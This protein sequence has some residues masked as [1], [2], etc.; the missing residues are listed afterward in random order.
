MANYSPLTNFSIKKSKASKE[1]KGTRFEN[2]YFDNEMNQ[3]KD[4]WFNQSSYGQIQGIGSN[5]YYEKYEDKLE[6]VIV[7]VIDSGVDVNHED[8]DG[9][10]WIN[11]NEI[12]NNGID[13]DGNGYI[14]DVMGW[15]FIG[16]SDY[17]A[18]FKLDN[19]KMNG[20]TLINN[21]EGQVEFDS[22]EITRETKR[23]LNLQLNYE[24]QGQIFPEHLLDKLNSYQE[25]VQ[26]EY[27]N[28]L[29]SL[30]YFQ[31]EQSS[32]TTLLNKVKATYNLKEV[33]LRVLENLEFKDSDAYKLID[34]Y[35]VYD[36]PEL[37]IAQSVHH[38]NGISNYHYNINASTRVD[39]VKDK[40]IK[41]FYGNNNVVGPDPYHGTHV[42]GIIAAIRDND[43]GIKGIASN[44]LIMPLRVVPN[45][46]ERDKDVANSII[47]AVD[48][49]AQ[50]INMS[51]GKAQSPNTKL[52]LDAIKYAQEKNVLLI[53]ASGNENKNID[54]IENYPTAFH[55]SYQAS[56]WVEVGAS[57]QYITNLFANFSNFG[58]SK[59]D[60]FAPGVSIIS[61]TPNNSY[62]KASGT[63]MATPVVSGIAAV[64]KGK[65]PKLTPEE[66]KDI[67]MTTGTRYPLRYV[68]N[69]EAGKSVL[70]SNLSK[71][72]SI[73]NL[74]K[75][76]N[77]LKKNYVEQQP[78]NLSS[79]G[80]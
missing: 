66:L 7:A 37:E 12:P 10:I 50:I 68:Y 49:G 16:G 14:D 46:D 17:P 19:T 74:L 2:V 72:G 4:G 39:I 21:K 5:L 27:E 44:A 58:A 8:L 25:K 24:E 78:I 60:L 32:F 71:S 75:A 52:V 34:F 56:N 41:R 63:S 80:F 65:Y 15:N 53:H 11:K 70:F 1:F 51:F 26:T 30:K 22:F 3:E 69:P 61:T 6:K 45:G 79:F 13:D 40:N 76:M 35:E 43:M 36:N 28:S 73:P 38:L 23:L 55:S 54:I 18:S 48:N 29:E 47:Y 20:L 33:N 64:I 9:K 67:L 42:A 77:Y 59:V 57:N 62:A 31:E